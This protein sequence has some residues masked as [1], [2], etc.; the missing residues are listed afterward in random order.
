MVEPK[1]RSNWQGLSASPPL[2]SRQQELFFH[3]DV[4]EQSR[5]ELVVH[6][7]VYVIG[8]G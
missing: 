4:P 3:A 5:A 7:L 2:H 8:S 1:L 6:R